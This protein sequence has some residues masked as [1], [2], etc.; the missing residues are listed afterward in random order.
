MCRYKLVKPTYP[1]FSKSTRNIGLTEFFML[2]INKKYFLNRNNPNHQQNSH[3]TP[4]YTSPSDYLR[5]F[6]KMAVIMSISF[7]GQRLQ[8]TK[9]IF[10]LIC[11]R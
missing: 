5:T 1:Y 8:G 10:P 4:L 11:P 9:G 7:D 2:A 6:C 3:I